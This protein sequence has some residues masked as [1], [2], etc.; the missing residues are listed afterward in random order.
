[1][2]L[3]WIAAELNPTRYSLSHEMAREPLVDRVRAA[4]KR[5]PRVAER[6]M[7]GGITFMVNGK[8]CISVGP[9]RL[10]CRIDPQL[11]DIALARK[12]AR[13]VR[14]KG[15]VY[16]GFLHVHKDA[17]KSKRALDYWVGLCLTFNKR[18]KSSRP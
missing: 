4:L 17:I 6:R 8:M 5:T 2:L 11:H 16:R 9:T 7:F 15:R 14:M 1:M 10:M 12:G 13:P 3:S 18:A